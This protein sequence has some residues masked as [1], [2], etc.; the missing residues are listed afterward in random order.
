MTIRGLVA[1]WRS[2]V[3]DI[4][5]AVQS[6]DGW[7]ERARDAAHRTTAEYAAEQRRLGLKYLESLRKQSP[8]PQEAPFRV[9]DRAA[10]RAR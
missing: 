8:A 7:R 5:N 6:M 2:V 3:G 4:R 9:D 10:V 1:M